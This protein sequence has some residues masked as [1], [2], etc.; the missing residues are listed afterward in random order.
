[1]APPLVFNKKWC[2]VAVWEKPILSSPRSFICEW[3]SCIGQ[4][5]CEFWFSVFFSLEDC[6]APALAPNAKM[7][8]VIAKISFIFCSPDCDYLE[9]TRQDLTFECDSSG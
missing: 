1:M 2:V 3:V 8:I 6:R 4:T 9:S 5:A 7:K